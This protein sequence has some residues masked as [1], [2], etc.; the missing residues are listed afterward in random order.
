MINIS[1]IPTSLYSF[2]DFSIN[3]SI[4]EHLQEISYG[5]SSVE[6]TYG[7]NKNEY[8]NESLIETNVQGEITYKSS[9]DTV[10]E[11]DGEGNVEILMPGDTVITAVAE[12]ANG[13]GEGIASYTLKVN[14]RAVNITSATVNNKVYDGTTTADVDDF[15]VDD[16]DYDFLGAV[17]TFD[18]ANVG[19][20][21]NVNVTLNLDNDWG[22][23]FT[24]NIYSATAD[25]EAFE[26]D[27]GLLSQDQYIYSGAENRPIVRIPVSLDGEHD[28]YLTEG[29]DFDVTYP[30]DTINAGEKTI[31]VSGKN[32][33]TGDF[34]PN[35]DVDT[36][37]L[38]ANNITLEYG[39][40]EWDGTPKTPGVT[41]KVGDVTIDDDDY[42]VE[43]ADNTAA[44]TATVTVTAKDDTNI[45]S[46]ASKTFEITQKTVLDISGVSD[47][48]V[49]YTGFPVVLVGD[50]TVSGGAG[51][52]ADDLTVKWYDE[53]GVN[54]ISRPTE[55]GSYVVVYSLDNNA[56][57]TGSL[58]VNFTIA[59]ANSPMPSEMAAGLSVEAGRSLEDIED[60]RTDGF[61]WE[62]DN[63]VVAP[64]LNYYAATYTYKNNDNYTTLHLNVPVYGY[65]LVN[66]NVEIDTDGG[67][68]EYP[69]E[70][71]EGEAFDVR[72][73]PEA[74]YELKSVM[75]NGMEVTSSVKDN[76]LRITAGTTDVDI[77]A[78]FRRVYNTIEGEGM[79]YVIGAGRLAS[80]RFNVDHDLF[81]NGGKVYIDGQ[82]I[83][84]GY[85]THTSGS[86]IITLSEELLNLFGNGD[87]IIAVVFGDGGIARASFSV[88]GATG[89]SPIKTPNTG[90][91]SGVIG[92]VRAISITALIF[93]GIASVVVYR[94]KFAGKRVD[95]DKK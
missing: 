70:V 52:T 64:G 34:E 79:N 71:I 88:A 27:D 38:T 93:A 77:L 7:D 40:V 28:V 24:T 4:W 51:I 19:T 3:F 21:K 23:Y 69:D 76:I 1:N 90:F 66:V 92:G 45:D 84:E 58:T 86:T 6:L 44:G 80:F 61:W 83:G 73:L 37:T 10:A 14:K 82:L 2:E 55:A 68:V 30:D 5:E 9:D 74:S 16:D 56:N 17:A 18:D 54:E 63:I 42:T 91:F 57:Y 95:F 81:V 43:Y 31:S 13:Y 25:I 8:K 39:T 48:S 35:Y 11:V 89:E 75:L 26:I 87:H 78:S 50:L 41:V 15:T 49:T 22:R 29:T 32:N 20:G 85:Y 53:E 72:F 60:D 67:D 33:F 46:Y 94:K 12:A 47:Q 62:D 59:K 36:Y 65:A